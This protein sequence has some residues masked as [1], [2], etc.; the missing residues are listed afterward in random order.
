[1]DSCAPS[2]GL[3]GYKIQYQSNSFAS[4]P[5]IVLKHALHFHNG[6]LI[7]NRWTIWHTAKNICRSVHKIG[8]TSPSRQLHDNPNLKDLTIRVFS[9]IRVVRKSNS[10]RRKKKSDWC[11]FYWSWSQPTENYFSRQE[12]KSLVQI[13]IANHYNRHKI[14][15]TENLVK[16]NILPD[17]GLSLNIFWYFCTFQICTSM[18]LLT[19]HYHTSICTTVMPVHLDF[20]Q[21]HLITNT[22][23]KIK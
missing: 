4:R 23:Y 19:K 13:I 21:S 17:Q 8:I 2:L 5:W 7:F 20:L 11:Q 3:S 18:P 6:K 9:H 10:L 12:T 15:D 16:G 22:T 1:M 14:L